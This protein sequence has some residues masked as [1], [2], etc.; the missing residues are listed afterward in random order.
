M[1]REENVIER[2]G[3]AGSLVTIE[4]RNEKYGNE[5]EQRDNGNM[6]IIN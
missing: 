3:V 4:K 1:K 6:R 5:M 2:D